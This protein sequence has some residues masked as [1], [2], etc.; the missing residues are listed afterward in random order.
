MTTRREQAGAVFFSVLMVVSMVAG[1]VAFGGLAAADRPDVAPDDNGDAGQPLETG[2][3]S[4]QNATVGPNGTATET[5]NETAAG[6]DANGTDSTDAGASVRGN[7]TGSEPGEA[8]GNASVDDPEPVN[9]TEAGN[10]SRPG[11]GPVDANV[12][13]ETIDVIDGSGDDGAKPTRVD[14]DPDDLPGNGT[15]AHPYRIANASELQA[16]ADDLDAN[17]TLV[18][19]IDASATVAWNNES[20]FDPIGGASSDSDTPRAFTGSFVGNG[21]IVSGLSISRSSEDYVGL[22]GSVA[23][24]GTVRGVSLTDANVTG[25]ASVGGLIGLSNGATVVSSSVAGTVT[26]SDDVG[27]LVGQNDDGTI[28]SSSTTGTVI[29]SGFGIGGL[30]GHNNGAVDTSYSTGAVTGSDFVGGLVGSNA[31]TVNSSYA[32]GPVTAE[33]SLVGGLVGS[34]DLGT[35]TG[36]YW[37]TEAT[38]Q[39]ASDGGTGL[40]TEEMTG[41]AAVGT[42]TAFEFGTNWEVRPNDYPKPIDRSDASADG[43]DGLPPFSRTV[44]LDPT[45]TNPPSLAG[46]FR[47]EDQ[48]ASSTNVTLLEN[49]ST[50][51][52]INITAPD[53]SENVTFYLQ[54]QATSASQDIDDIR[55]LLDGQRRAFTVVADAGPGNSSWIGFTVPEFSTRTVTFTNESDSRDTV[56]SIVAPSNATYGPNNRLTIGTYHN[57][58]GVINSSDVVVRLVNA[59]DGNDTVVAV[60]DSAPVQGAV[61]TTIPA[62]SL[63]GTVKIETQLYNSSTQQ[64]VATDTVVLTVETSDVSPTAAYDFEGTGSTVVDRTGNG[65]TGELNG[66]NR[67]PG[68]NGTVLSFDRSSYAQLGS[69]DTLDPRNG[70]Y[71]VSLWFKTDSV[72]GPNSVLFA[73]RGDDNER[74]K[75]ALHNNG[76]GEGNVGV[77]FKDDPGLDNDG[78][79]SSETYTDGTWHRVLVVRDAGTDSIELYV[80]GELIG[81]TTDTQGDINPTGPAYLGAQ[82]EYPNDRYYT[83]QLDDVRVS[84]LSLD[85]GE[86]SGAVP[87]DVDP[88][89]LDGNGSESN[90]YEISNASELQAMED[91]LDAN[92]TLVT[93]IN[94]SNT[95][96]WNNGRGFDP[97]GDAPFND[98]TPTAFTGSFDG[99]NH[100]ITG[101]TIDRPDAN[102]VGLFGYSDGGNSTIQRVTASGDVNGLNYVGGLAGYF[103]GGNSCSIENAVRERDHSVLVSFLR[104]LRANERMISR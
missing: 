52:S 80:D 33:F 95:A 55:M 43:E 76:S 37:D 84:K 5:G 27:I 13:S 67:V 94:A 97:I 45:Q 63:A 15:E 11:D 81:T 28:E 7:D 30:V 51:Y 75:I 90:P 64:V 91:D 99:D 101:L 56:P 57:A 39:S 66:A 1:S 36:S 60:T 10:A 41:Q 22:F 68:R 29:G 21:Y 23:D 35:V 79:R 62:G 18:S 93:D 88:S 89:D 38:N 77:N 83:G 53:G 3:A 9:E 104:L 70:S 72:S 31:G 59:T 86:E 87:V 42:M 19:D 82:P 49:S 54:E 103:D 73:K 98:S 6:T 69:A 78:I 44:S 34:N 8:D 24:T 102:Y 25:S 47:V 26:G 58:T 85:P 65:Y 74:V 12:T 32:V 48:V 92:Y 71:S 96:Q 40:T 2:T 17:Y 61:N 100:T 50:E 46:K 20:G 4:E 14:V 16:M